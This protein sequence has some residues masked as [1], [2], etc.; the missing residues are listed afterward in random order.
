MRIGIV[1]AG[2]VGGWMGARLAAAGHTV[3]MVARGATLDS[4]QTK[5]LT[6]IEDTGAYTTPIL[7]ARSCQ[8]LDVQDLVVIAVKSTAMRAVAETIAP[9]LGRETLVTSAMNGVPWWFCNGLPAPYTNQRIAAADVDGYIAAAIPLECTLGCVVLASASVESAGTVR[10][11]A[12]NTLIVGDATGRNPDRA[13]HVIEMFREARFETKYSGFIHADV[14]YK[15]WGNLTMN[16]LSAII[17]TTTDVLLNDE[18]VRDFATAVMSEA[19]E[20]GTR[21]GVH[22][23]QQP[24]ERHRVTLGLGAMTTSMLQDVASRK[25]VELNTLVGAVCELGRITGVQTP[26]TNA[27]FGI[28]R[29]HATVRGL[30]VA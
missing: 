6:C 7:A 28:S 13:G 2:A 19:K 29:L 11:N 4:L 30:Y 21:L 14:W 15:L 24:E 3:S 22:I 20:I 8:D 16:P 18:L 9:F 17:G 12:G 23:E 5:G 1:G 26:F 25:P 10:L 27:L